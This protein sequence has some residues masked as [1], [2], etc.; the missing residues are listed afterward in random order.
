MCEHVFQDI[1]MLSH[2]FLF[3]CSPASM[4]A[5]G[6]ASVMAAL[7]AADKPL[8]R[9]TSSSSRHLQQTQA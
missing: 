1:V 6:Q 7:A 9:P 2:V 3:V 8:Q 4:A 5:N